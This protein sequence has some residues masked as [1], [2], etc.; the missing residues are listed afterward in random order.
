M[1]I[2]QY[3]FDGFQNQIEQK[4]Q[5]FRNMSILLDDVIGD[6]VFFSFC[7]F[8]KKRISFFFVHFS[9]F[10]FFNLNHNDLNVLL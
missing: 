9:F 2:Y 5:F 10:F 8:L 6:L 1:R 7:F 4:M 3:E